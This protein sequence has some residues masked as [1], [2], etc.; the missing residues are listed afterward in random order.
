MEETT[1]IGYDLDQIID[2]FGLTK[3]S[4][5]TSLSKWLA[6]RYPLDASELAIV[7]KL[8]VEMEATGE[9]LNE[10]ELKMKFVGL[11][12]FLAQLDVPGKLRVFYERKLSATIGSHA[13]SV[14]CDCLVASPKGLNTPQTPYFFFQEFKKRKGEK[15]DPE[16]QMLTAMLIGQHKNDNNKPVYGGYLIGPYW[17]FTVLNDKTYS[18]SRNF[19]ATQKEDI[20]QIIAMLKELKVMIL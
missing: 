7:D 2:T 8:F 14:K 5:G 10:E 12:F 13:L 11:V 6:A 16:A 19:D 17:R 1:K 9:Q 18:V 4:N 15:D 20:V 3:G